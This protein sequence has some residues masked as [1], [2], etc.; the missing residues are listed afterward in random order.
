MAMKY[1]PEIHHRRSTRLKE[2]DHSQA[3]T[4]FI[5]ICTWQKECLLGK[6]VNGEIRLNEFGGIVDTFWKQVPNHFP[7]VALDKFIIM[8][9]HMH[10]IVLLNDVGAIHELPLQSESPYQNR[11]KRRIMLLPKIMGRFKMNSSKTI[12]QIRNT[13]GTPLWQRNYFER[14]IRDEY[15]L[16][17]I[18]QYIINNPLQWDMDVNNPVNL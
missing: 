15:E 12:N 2:Y 3:G 14:V 18:R 10:V 17:A 16:H 8:P 9:N 1:N 4:Y 11:I 5:T 13:P 7:N 6:V